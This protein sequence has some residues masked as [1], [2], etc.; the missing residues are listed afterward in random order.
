M[1]RPMT[2]AEKVRFKA[3]FPS[4]DVDRSV[5]TGGASSVYN[6]I[7]WTVGVT[8]RWLWPGSSLAN[9]DAFYKRFGFIRSGDGPI[10][11]WGHTD[12]RADPDTARDGNRNTGRIFEFNMAWANCS[13]APTAES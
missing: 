11:V 4:L 7:A 3:C 13:E 8:N 10:S 1:A 2:P 9:F 5:V 12:L 6:C